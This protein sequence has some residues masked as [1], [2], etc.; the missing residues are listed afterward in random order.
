M[1][2]PYHSANV[3]YVVVVLSCLG[4]NGNK[5]SHMLSIDTDFFFLSPTVSICGWLNSRQCHSQLG[6]QDRVDF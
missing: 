2:N 4:I 1:C 5:S 3:M 6:V